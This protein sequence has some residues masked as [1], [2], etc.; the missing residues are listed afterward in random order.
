MKGQ[1]IKRISAFEEVVREEDGFKIVRYCDKYGIID[2]DF[3]QIAEIEY[4][5]ISFNRYIRT[6]F[7]FRFGVLF[8]TGI[9]DGTPEFGNRRIPG[10]SIRLSGITGAP[11]YKVSAPRTPVKPQA[12]KLSILLIQM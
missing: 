10:N 3:N 11:A 2:N 8:A 9:L 1:E 5:D 7:D 6:I 4:D 12:I